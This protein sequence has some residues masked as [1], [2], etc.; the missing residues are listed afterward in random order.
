MVPANTTDAKMQLAPPLEIPGP[1][2]DANKVAPSR[3]LDLLLDQEARQSVP[4]AGTPVGKS[5]TASSTI[6]SPTTPPPH[7]LQS[8]IGDFSQ[9]LEAS[10]H[11]RSP[12]DTASKGEAKDSTSGKRNGK[13]VGVTPDI[14]E[15]DSRSTPPQY[16][17]DVAHIARYPSDEKYRLLKRKLKDVLEVVIKLTLPM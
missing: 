8:E 1:T 11:G 16:G 9:E 7:R 17:Q 6:S 13:A 10:H 15:D 2:T 4:A 5:R 3:A 12:T 14:E